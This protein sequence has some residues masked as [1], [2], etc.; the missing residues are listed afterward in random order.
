M[1]NLTLKIRETIF[2]IFKCGDYWAKMY[3]NKYWVRYVCKGR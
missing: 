1:C 3:W 2:I